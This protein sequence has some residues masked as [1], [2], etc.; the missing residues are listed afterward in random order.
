MVVPPG[1][2]NTGDTALLTPPSLGMDAE[3]ILADVIHYHSRMLGRH[4]IKRSEHYL[5][6]ALVHAARDR[7]MERWIET[8]NR[9]VTRQGKRAC[10]LSLEFLMGRLLRNALLNLEMTDEAA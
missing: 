10:Y 6:Q 3:A 1:P 4:T 8:R 2:E 7:L 5:F 9:L